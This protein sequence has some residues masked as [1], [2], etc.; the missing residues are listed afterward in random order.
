VFRV[1][2]QEIWRTNVSGRTSEDGRFA[3]R[4]FYGRYDVTVTW[5]GQTRTVAVEHVPGDSPTV[6]RIEF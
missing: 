5:H 1:L 3:A 6:V 4:A 2:T